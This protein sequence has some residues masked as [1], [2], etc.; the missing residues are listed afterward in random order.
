VHDRRRNLSAW[1]SR[2]HSWHTQSS[3]TD[4]V[5]VL[6]HLAHLDTQVVA[7]RALHLFLEPL[8]LVDARASDHKIVDLDANKQLVVDVDGELHQC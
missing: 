4:A 8:D 7:E 1:P 2:G 5:R 3:E 6:A